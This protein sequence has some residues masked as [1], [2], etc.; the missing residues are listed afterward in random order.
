MAELYRT[1]DR[2]IL[3]ASDELQAPLSAVV[4]HVT[5]AIITK[6]VQRPKAPAD[7]VKADGVKLADLNADF[8]VKARKDLGVL[9]LPKK[10]WWQFWR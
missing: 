1:S 2:V 9:P 8:L 6:S 3:L 5:G 7:D 4:R 10:L